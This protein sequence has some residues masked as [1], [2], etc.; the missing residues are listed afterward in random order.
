MNVDE[1]KELLVS[2]IVYFLEPY[3]EKLHQ[4]SIQGEG[5]K[6]DIVG[7]I[8]DQATSLFVLVRIF[9]SEEFRKIYIS[10]IN[11]PEFMRHQGVGRKVI[12]VIHKAATESGYE[13]FVA[14]V[15]KSFY[16]SLIKRGALECDKINMLK[17]V[18]STVLD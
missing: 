11:L 10:N 6:I 7:A 18:N 14:L 16:D 5:G 15:P 3:L 9:I 1:I 13:L 17:I 4:Y 12:K 8:D 2:R